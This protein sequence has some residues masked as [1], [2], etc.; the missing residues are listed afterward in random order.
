MSTLLYI[1]KFKKHTKIK[2]GVTTNL[3]YRIS[4]IEKKTGFNVDYYQSRIVTNSS[5]RKI[6]LLERNLL[7]ITLDFKYHFNKDFDFAGKQEFR[8]DNCLNLILQYISDQKDYGMKYKI[9]K[10]IDTCGFYNHKLPKVYFPID[11][12]L[13]SLSRV[14]AEDLVEYCNENDLN[15]VEIYNQAIYEYAVRNGFDRKDKPIQDYQ[16]FFKI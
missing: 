16:H 1:L 2:I 15:A 4:Q 14:L 10:G 6:T 9:Y 13:K 3:I 8:Q 7:E 5:K 11:F 12:T